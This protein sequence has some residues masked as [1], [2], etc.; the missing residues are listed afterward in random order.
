V[1]ISLSDAHDVYVAAVRPL[2]LVHERGAQIVLTNDTEVVLRLWPDPSACASARH[3]VADF[4]R[5]RDVAHLVDD[6]ELLTSEIVTNAI[7]YAT[8]LITL[9]ATLR[10]GVLVVGVVGDGPIHAE[11]ASARSPELSEHGRGLF[12]VDQLADGWGSSRHVGGTT[13]WFR[14]C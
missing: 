10:D 7:R 4:C 2:P 8:T 11:L 14:L 12:V 5:A 6:A 13:V 3:A 1:A 9:V